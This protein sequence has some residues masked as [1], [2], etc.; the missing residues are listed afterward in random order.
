MHWSPR[1]CIQV[2]TSR[3]PSG[4]RS[5]I[6]SGGPLQLVPSSEFLPGVP[7]K[8]YPPVDPLAGSIQEVP[9]RGSSTLVGRFQGGP[10]K[11]SPTVSHTMRSPQ[12]VSV[13]GAP[14][15]C[16][17]W[18]VS[19]VIQTR[20]LSRCSHIWYPPGRSSSF[21]LNRGSTAGGFTQ[22]DLSKRS[23]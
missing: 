3:D 21:V 12:G 10:F 4:S 14:P 19:Q 16:T 8:G 17:L 15:W 13:Q 1:V 22:W 9:S 2:G 5:E 7:S 6:P 18:A 11:W 20:G 23:H